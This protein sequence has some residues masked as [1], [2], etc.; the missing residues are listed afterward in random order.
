MVSE[1][2]AVERQVDVARQE[3]ISASDSPGKAGIAGQHAEGRLRNAAKRYRYALAE[4][5]LE[6][7]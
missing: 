7:M 1:I 6:R 3:Y 2:R 4:Q 5:E